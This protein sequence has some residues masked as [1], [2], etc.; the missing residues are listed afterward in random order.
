MLT[1]AVDWTTEPEVQGW[2]LH[3]P[4]GKSLHD[5]RPVFIGRDL[6]LPQT[7]TDALLY[8]ADWYLGPIPGF[9]TPNFGLM[10]A[11]RPTES[12]MLG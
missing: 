1:I 4:I 2:Y 8:G 7:P 5:A 10:R 11:R 3:A 12:R 9:P 6:L